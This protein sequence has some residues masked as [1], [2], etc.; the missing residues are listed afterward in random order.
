MGAVEAANLRAWT[1]TRI[2]ANGAQPLVDWAIVDE[3]FTD[4]FFEQTVERA[5]GH[6]F[7]A[8]FAQRRPIGALEDLAAVEPGLG[9]DGFIFHMSRCGSTLVAQM[10]AALSSTIVLSEAQPLDALLALRSRRTCDDEQIVKWLRATTSVLARPRLG[11]RRL[12]VKFNAWHVLELPLIARAFPDVPWIFLFREPRAVL[13]SHDTSPGAEV[14]AGT[15]DPAYADIE[16]SDAP[17]VPQ[18]E[19]RAR[20]LA[21]FCEAALRHADVGRGRFVDYAALPEIVFS[22]LL[23]FFGVTL[24]DV[25]AQ[26]MLNAAGRDAKRAGAAFRPRALEHGA[27]ELDRLA[28]RW[29]DAAYQQLGAGAARG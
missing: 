7:N 28:T 19:Y 5:M 13:R 8:V 17:F 16:P 12:F 3:P 22:E 29:L 15:L 9:P 2:R 11:E 18:D 27:P 10:L 6:P 23:D 14:I 20:M 26:A 25:E 24:G 21:A 4:P 1:P